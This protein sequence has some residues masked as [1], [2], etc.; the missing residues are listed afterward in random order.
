MFQRLGNVNVNIEGSLKEL[1]GI[2]DAEF[3]HTKDLQNK[4]YI[5]VDNDFSNVEESREEQTTVQ[6]V[7]MSNVKI[8]IIG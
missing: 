6:T 4:H 3:G 1:R 8:K 2:L 7:Y 5:F